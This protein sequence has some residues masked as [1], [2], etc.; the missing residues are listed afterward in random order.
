LTPDGEDIEVVLA[1]GEGDDGHDGE[2]DA[3]H[4]ETSSSSGQN[5]HFHAGV[6]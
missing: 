4:N 1:A 5:C 2:D 6:E 3:Q